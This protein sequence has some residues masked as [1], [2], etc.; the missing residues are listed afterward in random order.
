MSHK[1]TGIASLKGA[2]MWNRMST[3]A[4]ED[5]PVFWLCWYNSRFRV[6]V[7]VHEANCNLME[8]SLH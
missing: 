5:R 2:F 1:Q 4:R 8:N 6:E 3:I 7:L